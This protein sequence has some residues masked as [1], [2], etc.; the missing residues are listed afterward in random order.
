[1]HALAAEDAYPGSAWLKTKRLDI[2]VRKQDYRTALAMTREPTE[3]AALATAA[4]AS[5]TSSREAF[6][7]AKQAVKS[8]TGTGAG[9]CR[10]RQGAAAVGPRA[11]GPAGTR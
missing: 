11:G 5:A 1:M 6:A 2:A 7:Y 9:D 10:L 8:S 4:A 3:I